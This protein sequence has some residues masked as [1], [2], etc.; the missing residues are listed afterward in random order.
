MM[1]KL[2]FNVC[3][4]ISFFVSIR[5]G[6][7]CK[8]TIYYKYHNFTDHRKVDILFAK[9]FKDHAALKT[10]ALLDFPSSEFSKSFLS[11]MDKR[12]FDFEEAAPV[13]PKIDAE[14]LKSVKNLKTNRTIFLFIFKKN[15]DLL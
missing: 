9:G 5:P 6:E 15:C 14:P 11:F 2:F 4:I 1:I 3:F 8:R 10:K 12:R 13:K 7:L